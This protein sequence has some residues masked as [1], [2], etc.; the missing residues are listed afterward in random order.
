MSGP[1]LIEF[2]LDGTLIDS[3]PDIALAVDRLLADLDL[4]PPGVERVRGWIGH[5]ARRLLRS[6]LVWAGADDADATVERE[7]ERFMVHYGD[8]LCI[9]T[10]IYPGTLDA[11]DTLAADGALL[12]VCTNKPH[13][14]V[15]PLLRELGIADRFFEWIGGDF[16]E[17]R[18][19]DPEPLLWLARRAGVPPGECLMVGDSRAD[20]DAAKAA[21][22]PVVVLRHG[23]P[24]ETDLSDAEALFDDFAA[25]P[26]WVR[27]QNGR[28]WRRGGRA[29][30]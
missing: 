6:A 18:K 17:R 4:P 26:P 29:G 24:G 5:G 16:L 27:A 30:G 13:R 9:E 7:F 19:P 10:R 23:Y 11:L 25:L 28:L 12:A 22:M 21:G 20:V 2:D 1:R 3:A 14:H 8:C 15:E